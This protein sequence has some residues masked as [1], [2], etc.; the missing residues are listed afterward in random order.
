MEGSVCAGCHSFFPQD[1]VTCPGCG[2]TIIPDGAAKNIIDRLLPDCLIHRYDG[3][4][5]L[6]PAVVIKQGKANVKVATRLKEY[7]DPV[8][9]PRAKVYTFDQSVLGSI[10]AL[11]NERTATVRRYD[12]LIA[13]HW[14][15][16]KPLYDGPK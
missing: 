16:L 8:T 5:M 1:T 11:R 4:D 9:V 6:E 2:E 10:Q 3:S 15:Q 12:Q 7:A 14:K 13:S